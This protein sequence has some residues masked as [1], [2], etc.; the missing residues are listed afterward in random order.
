VKKNI[1]ELIESHEKQ[2]AALEIKLHKLQR[3]TGGKPEGPRELIIIEIR[4]SIQLT[5][6]FINELTGLK[7][8]CDGCELR[9]EKSS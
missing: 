3:Q 8:K 7:H 4:Q 5:R 9:E 6:Q 2:I 1:T